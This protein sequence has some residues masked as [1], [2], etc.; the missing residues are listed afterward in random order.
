MN[1]ETKLS[2]KEK[3][4]HCAVLVRGGGLGDFILSL[5]LVNYIQSTYEEVLILTKPSY[6][7]LVQS[8]IKNTEFFELDLGIS[9]FGE[10]LK[11]SDV[12]TFWKDG[13]WIDELKK[14]HVQKVFILPAKPKSPP[15]IIESI[16]KVLSINIPDSY[17]SKPCLGDFWVQSLTLWIHSGSGSKAK[18]IPF[19]FYKKLADDW[20]RNKKEN[21]VV[22]SFGEADRHSLDL[23]KSETF[24]YP[25]RIQLIL[26]RSIE[27]YKEILLKGVAQ[28][29]G[30]DSGPSHLAANLGIPTNVCFRST[31]PKIWRPTGPRVYVHE[32]TQDAN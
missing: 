19:S 30:N 14:Y 3:K 18:N 28:F 26:P 9:Q 12:F 27:E 8:K 6:F 15:H 11:D 31:N 32:F 21:Q 5:P 24:C 7:C 16:F 1:F 10:R 23:F 4:K 29:W 20:L 25:D 2:L 17:L 22:F 13:E